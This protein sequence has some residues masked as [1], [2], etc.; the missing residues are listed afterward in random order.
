MIYV[1]KGRAREYSPYALNTYSGCS[2]GCLYCYAPRVRYMERE[3]FINETPRKDYEKVLTKDAVKFSNLSQQVLLN[4]IGDPYCKLNDSLQYT[5]LTI[6]TL[7]VNKIPVAI[8][9]KGGRRALHD[10]GII[11]LGGSHIKYGATLTFEDPELSSKW[12]PGAA[13]PQDRF[14]TLKKFHEQGVKTW[15]SFEPVIDPVQ[16]LKVIKRVVGYV[17]EFRLGKIN[18]FEGLDKKINWS[19]DFLKPALEILRKAGKQIYV[20][21]DLRKASPLV[22]LSDDEV[23]CDNYLSRPFD[24]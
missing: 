17:D 8:L 3:D 18:Q 14:D 5:R 4:F 21:H 22:E 6:M 10:L 20:K 11:K 24:D 12:E 9:S 1:P 23:N 16:S 7:L 13:L 15:A 2:H 19:D